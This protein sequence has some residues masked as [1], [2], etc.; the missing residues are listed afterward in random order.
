MKRTILC[1]ISCLALL[2]LSGCKFLFKSPTLEKVHDLKVVSIDPDEAKLELT[3]SVHNPNCYKLKL[4][5]MDVVLLNHNREPI[6]DAVLKQGVEIPK[7]RSNALAFSISLDTRSTVRMVNYSDQKV[8]LY[9]SGV[10]E[11]RV[12]GVKKKFE[13]EEPYEIDIREQLEQVVSSFK[14]DS[15][16]MF[17][18]K[19]SYISRVGLTESQV[20]VDF[21]ILNPYGLKFT[22]ESFPATITIGGKEAG[23]GDLANALSFDE[24]VYSHEGTMVFSISNLKAI[25]NI[26]KGALNGEVG[27]Q[28]DGRVKIRAYGLDVDRPFT[29]K[30][31]IVINI[32]DEILKLI[33]I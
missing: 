4:D 32:T 12:A 10:G 15:Q 33:G 29:Y 21:I 28:V 9:I 1:L 8:F 20:S 24:K 14:A 19:R 18:L 13:F 5:R 11:G 23:R 17:V 26:A 22:L 31:K 30:D 2:G 6:G 3:L 16:D 25:L 7:K 27:Y